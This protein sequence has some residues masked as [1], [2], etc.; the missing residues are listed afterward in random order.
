MA[1]AIRSLVGRMVGEPIPEQPNVV[2]RLLQKYTNADEA[3][4]ARQT[5]SGSAA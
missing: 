5:N 4:D 1:K 2:K 3:F